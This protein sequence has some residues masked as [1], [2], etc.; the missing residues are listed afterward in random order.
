MGVCRMLTCSG[1][2]RKLRRA[3][4]GLSRVHRIGSPVLPAPISQAMLTCKHML[5]HYRSIVSLLV[6]VGLTSIGVDS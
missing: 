6:T 3:L 1:I 2:P 5:N 4:T